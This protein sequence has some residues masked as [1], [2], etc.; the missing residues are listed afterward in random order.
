M[1]YRIIRITPESEITIHDVSDIQQNMLEFNKLLNELIG[2]GCDCF[3]MVT[4][5]RLYTNLG[6]SSV[7][8]TNVGEYAAMLV[9][10]EGAIKEL[11]VNPIGSFLY[12]SDIHN[13]FIYG[14]ILIIGVY[15]DDLGW[16]F[17]GLRK[18]TFDLLCPK[19]EEMAKRFTANDGYHKK[20]NTHEEPL[21]LEPEDFSVDEYRVLC[22]VF[23]CPIGTTRMKVNWKSVE[24]FVDADDAKKMHLF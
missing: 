1:R 13:N 3:E 9:D 20:E 19:L 22:K 24:Y 15:Q 16:S 21:I 7:V 6:A 17:S 11:K 18:Y 2:D 8:T 10:E 5:K 4:P 14:T 23:G 12:E